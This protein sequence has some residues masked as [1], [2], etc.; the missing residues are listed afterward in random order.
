LGL[1][2]LA[3]TRSGALVGRDQFAL[4]EHVTGDA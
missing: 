3:G 2:A 4:G 1:L